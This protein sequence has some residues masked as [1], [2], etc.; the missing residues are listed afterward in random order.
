MKVGILTYHD[1]INYGAFFQVYSLQSFLLRH[2][3]E[4]NVIN[5]KN[6][7]FTLREYKVFLGPQY[8]YPRA[9][10]KGGVFKNI[11]KIFSFKKA[12]QKLHLTERFFKG[13]KLSRLDFDRIIIGSDE[14]WNFGTKLIG[15]DPVYFSNGLKADRIISYAASFGNRQVHETIP[16]QLCS[17]LGRIDSISVRD[18]NSA[19]IISGIIKKKVPITLDPTFLVDLRSEAITLHE[20]DYILIYGFFNK[21]MVERILEYARSVGKKTVSVG[22]NRP[23]CDLSLDT[24]SPFQWLGCFKNCDCVIT[25]MFHGMIFSM[26]NKKRFCMFSSPYRINKVGN[27]LFDLGLSEHF[28]NENKSIDEALMNNI[29]YIN[30]NALIEKKRHES[31]NFLLDAL[32]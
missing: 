10:V 3:Y 25:T 4:C 24:L 21:V 29:D 14:V 20:D 8:W 23:W 26:L 27:F 31:K 13:D 7:G 16:D 19:S 22:Y 5:Y 30:V 1:G 18:D 11:S 28:I 2:G 17:L 32:Q 9:L 15:Y 6:I 12:H